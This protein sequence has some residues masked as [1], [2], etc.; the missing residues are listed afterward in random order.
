MAGRL[1]QLGDIMPIND[2]AAYAELINPL[3]SDFGTNQGNQQLLTD[4]L[5]NLLLENKAAIEQERSQ[6][7]LLQE[8]ISLGGDSFTDQNVPVESG[9]FQVKGNPYAT[10]TADQ[11]L[12]TYSSVDEILL[13]QAKLAKEQLALEA[14]IKSPVSTLPGA[15]KR[16]QAAQQKALL[17][18]QTRQVDAETE[19]RR[20]QASGASGRGLD[21]NSPFAKA[22]SELLGVPISDIATGKV[23]PPD[24]IQKQVIEAL[25]L[26]S[27]QANYLYTLAEEAPLERFDTTE[28]LYKVGL[29]AKGVVYGDK[30]FTEMQELKYKV[31]DIARTAAS[32]NSPLQDLMKSDDPLA[33]AIA[34]SYNEDTIRNLIPVTRQGTKDERETVFR[35]TFQ[36][37]MTKAVGTHQSLYLQDIRPTTAQ[38]SIFILPAEHE[39]SADAARVTVRM[40][41]LG[42]DSY[43]SGIQR[44]TQAIKDLSGDQYDVG[45]AKAMVTAAVSK[46]QRKYAQFG[47]EMNIGVVEKELNRFL[48]PTVYEQLVRGAKRFR[49]NEAP[50]RLAGRQTVDDLQAI[51][52]RP[53]G[54]P[55]PGQEPVV[56]TTAVTPRSLLTGPTSTLTRDLT[57]R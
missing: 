5:H 46:Y 45:L 43:Q 14:Q 49:G 52:T 35:A 26:S 51:L 9:A 20:A 4:A 24:A 7:D 25:S 2:P 42:S 8:Y 16:E 37:F 36:D 23:R 11:G 55:I 10:P 34:R 29:D 39:R 32:S 15:R 53:S 33:V 44:L 12:R 41:E 18:L 30:E 57:G 22:S 38:P 47:S 27:E 50:T 17:D 19:L 28:R 3:T 56:D 40:N 13:E 31:A 21:P 48:A 6:Y 1:L 54:L